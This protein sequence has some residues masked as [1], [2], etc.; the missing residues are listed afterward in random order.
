MRGAAAPPC[1]RRAHV[2]IG[3][4][5]TLLAVAGLACGGGSPTSPSSAPS[6][7]SVE[8]RSAQL[9]NEARRA[10]GLA[11]L[12]VDPLL[13]DIARRHSEDMRDRGYFGHVD[14]NGHGFSDRLI[15]GGV[16]FSLVGENLA[17]VGSSPDPASLAHDAFLG[18]PGHRANMLNPEFTEVGVGVA[19]SSS[20]YWITQLYIRP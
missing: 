16:A 1:R 5:A 18:N 2:L 17:R 7:A 13:S 10:E 11:A 12:P 20:T 8:S 19:R 15:E 9:I 3:G 14:P 4:L 6:A